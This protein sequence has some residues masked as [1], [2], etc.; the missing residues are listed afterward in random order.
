VGPGFTKV[1]VRYNPEGDQEMNERQT[2]GCA[3]FGVLH[4]HHRKF[5]FELL[6]PAEPAQLER[7]GAAKSGTTSSCA[8]S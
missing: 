8:R 7:V 2:R 6:V 3:A 5:L 4:E 1:L